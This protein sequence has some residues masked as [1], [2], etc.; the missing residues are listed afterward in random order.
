MRTSEHISKKLKE[1]GIRFWS[2]DNISEEIDGLTSPNGK[3]IKEA[4]I[5]ETAEEFE[6]VLRS[7]LID[8]DTDPNAM[9]TAKRLSKMYWNEILSGRYEPEPVITA[10]PNGDVE[11]IDFVDTD[12]FQK[13]DGRFIQDYDGM[14]VVRAEIKSVCSHHHKDVNG[15]AYIGVLP[16]DKV[17]GLSKYIR[18]AQWHARR[19]TLQEELTK[20]IAHAISKVT[21]SP[22]VG[23]YIQATHGCVSCRGVG[24]ENSLTQTTVLLGRFREDKSIKKEFFD[25]ITLQE[26]RR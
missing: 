17:I 2:N 7:L 1:K 5:D 21:E 12:G 22:D 15:T 6:K 26:T 11:W 10:F 14:L 25:K 4:L 19:G 24:Q 20:R 16:K 18:L 8:I 23:V 9:G 3:P 13:K